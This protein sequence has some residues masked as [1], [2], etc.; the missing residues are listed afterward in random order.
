MYDNLELGVPTMASEVV[1]DESSTTFDGLSKDAVLEILR[2]KKEQLARNNQNYKTRYHTDPAFKKKH[3]ADNTRR[4]RERYHSDPD[5]RRKKLES[6]RLRHAKKRAEANAYKGYHSD[7][8]HEH[9]E[10]ADDHDSNS[11]RQ[12][13]EQDI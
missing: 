5:F 10:H 7:I 3:I 8:Y 9:P 6:D 11:L 1:V 4:R 13:H 12:V 2:K